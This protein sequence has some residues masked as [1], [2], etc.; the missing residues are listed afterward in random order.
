M[1]R[2]VIS[3]W[4]EIRKCSIKCLS[5]YDWTGTTLPSRATRKSW[6]SSRMNSST[7][8]WISRI[9]R[10]STLFRLRIQTTN[11]FTNFSLV[12]QFRLTQIR[13]TNIR[14]FGHDRRTDN[15]LGH[16]ISITICPSLK[17]ALRAWTPSERACRYHRL[18]STCYHRPKPVCPD[19]IRIYR[20]YSGSM[21]SNRKSYT[22]ISNC[23]VNLKSE[24]KTRTRSLEK[25]SSQRWSTMWIITTY[26]T[27][28]SYRSLRMRLLGQCKR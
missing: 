25:W 14:I 8:V 20:A 16:T 18:R 5:I 24:Y 17:P 10:P 26:R 27:Y 13:W 3:F 12:N 1:R 6:V 21:P 7:G 19:W 11:L 15:R 23:K 22:K 2:R 28:D 9:F 4:T